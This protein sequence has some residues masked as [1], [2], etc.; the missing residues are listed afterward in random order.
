MIN[1]PSNP[2][3]GDQYTSPSPYSNTWIF[4]GEGW[5]ALGSTVIGPIGPTGVP[6]PTGP[7]GALGPT[8]ATGAE[9]TGPWVIYDSSGTWTSYSDLSSAS[10][11]ATLGDS[12]ML[13][14]SNVIETPSSTIEIP[15]SVSIHLNGNT[16]QLTGS[17][18]IGSIIKL[19]SGCSIYDGTIQH[20]GDLVSPGGTGAVIELADPAKI[21]FE[22]VDVRNDSNTGLAIWKQSGDMIGG[23]FFSGG[24]SATFVSTGGGTINSVYCESTEDGASAFVHNSGSDG[25]VLINDVTAISR[26]TTGTG[27]GISLVSGSGQI[28]DSKGESYSFGDGISIRKPARFLGRNLVG[29]IRGLGL[30]LYSQSTSIY[31]SYFSG[32]VFLDFCTLTNSTITG[33]LE[34]N[35]GNTIINSRTEGLVNTF[36]DDVTLTIVNSVIGGQIDGSLHENLRL[37]IRGSS[38][39]GG[40]L[41][42]PM[43][44]SPQ[45]SYIVESQIYQPGG[46]LLYGIGGTGA[47]AVNIAISN[48]KFKGVVNG[49]DS[50]TITQ[51]ITA[52]ED[53]QG[54]II[55]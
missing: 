38:I 6:G 41:F 30:A 9:Y 16:Y 8:G 43:S 27:K 28:I 5:V 50:S 35:D 10:V 40:V 15:S 46:S 32:D 12:I 48:V 17:T 29:S 18:A 13:F 11:A 20:V 44:G 26:G 49:W 54:N 31:D 39:E 34:V 4:N 33:T 37:I 7:T 42:G 21:R 47:T 45:D 53:N 36:T 24:A 3:A 51:T 52:T 2:T 25:S 23:R 14:G 55:I 22:S 19:N 1:W